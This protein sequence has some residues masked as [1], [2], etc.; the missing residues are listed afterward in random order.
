MAHF[1]AL[2]EL[3]RTPPVSGYH[4]RE[5]NLNFAVQTTNVSEMA[6]SAKE[7][8]LTQKRVLENKTLEKIQKLGK[9]PYPADMYAKQDP[10]KSGTPCGKIITNVFGLNSNKGHGRRMYRYDVRVSGIPESGGKAADF[11]GTA[12][13]DRILIEKRDRCREVFT[14]FR[15]NE[16]ALLD[17]VTIYDLQSILFAESALDIKEPHVF[18]V[19]CAKL[20]DKFKNFKFVDMTVTKTGGADS[21]IIIGSIE[22]E[23]G[24]DMESNDRSHAQYMDILTGQCAIFDRDNHLSY[25]ASLSYL[26]SPETF[27]YSMEDLPPIEANHSFL[28]A[29]VFKS[30]HYVEGPKGFGHAHTGLVVEAKKTA[31]HEMCTAYDKAKCYIRDIT[32]IQNGDIGK[33]NIAMKGLAFEPNYGEKIRYYEIEEI[34]AVNARQKTITFQDGSQASVYDYFRDTYNVTLEHPD[35]PLIKHRGKELYFP[36]EVCIIS[37]NQRVGMQQQVPKSQEQMIKYAA[38][39]PA[40]RYEQIQS[41]L[42][43]LDF[44]NNKAMNKWGV[45]VVSTP[46][47]VTAGRVLSAPKI[48]FANEKIKPER[49]NTWSGKKYLIPKNLKTWAFIAFI[50]PID[51]LTP[52][53]TS[54]FVDALIASGQRYG[55]QIEQPEMAG[56]FTLHTDYE[57]IYTEI[58]KLKLKDHYQLVMVVQSK[59]SKAHAAIKCAERSNEILTQAIEVDTVRGIVQKGKPA[60]LANILNKTNVKLGGLNYSLTMEDPTS[61]RILGEGTLY[62]GIG[63]SHAVRGDIGPNGGQN[64]GNGPTSGQVPD[65][66]NGA[67]NGNGNNDTP[68]AGS[69]TAQVKGNP[70]VVGYAANIGV[71]H[72]FEFIG[73]FIFQEQSRDEKPELIG[74]IV[75]RCVMEYR[76]N[77]KCDVKRIVLYRNGCAEGQF[78]PILKYEVVFIHAALENVNCDA[79]VTIIVPNKMHNVRFFEEDPSEGLRNV[80]PGTIIDTHVVHPTFVEFYLNSHRA[81][82]GTARTPRFTVLLNEI[83]LKTDQLQNITHTLCYGH[84]IVYSP[85]SLPTP[86]YVANCYAE[87]GRMVYTEYMTRSRSMDDEGGLTYGQLEER[88]SYF[89]HPTFKNV[90]INA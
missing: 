55:M 16:K 49:F 42:K 23:L 79:K 3:S 28:G 2:P 18:R 82:Q 77:R 32:N 74:R 36:L 40:K 61:A 24:E 44:E 86:S 62:I 21:D 64:G 68:S 59:D 76:V 19:D 60:T 75:E 52:D 10:G 58:S 66:G 5:L 48:E 8:A 39:T 69:P 38:V 31:F 84:Q 35:A 90:R 53:D 33:L 81:L 72:P 34:T 85:T 9:Q 89:S 87:R 26:I 37:D 65:T 47:S 83:G 50:S 22:N 43:S 51:K 13:N 88:L 46:L 11:T 63:A 7:R 4:F 14:Y 45:S 57:K 41:N 17:V 80:Q 70:S 6:E 73:D 15:L 1:E 25:S 12:G 29:G 67:K 78:K 56:I 30:V 71:T 20:S 27:G 54:K